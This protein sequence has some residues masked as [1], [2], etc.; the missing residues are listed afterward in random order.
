VFG[1]DLGP[2]NLARG[3]ALLACDLLPPL[4]HALMWRLMGLH[5]ESNPWLR[6]P[7]A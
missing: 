1:L 2:V 5:G 6:A 3:A 4:K 7:Q